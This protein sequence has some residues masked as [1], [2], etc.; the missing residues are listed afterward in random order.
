MAISADVS[1]QGRSR[2]GATVAWTLFWGIPGLITQGVNPYME[3]GT[4]VA[5]TVTAEA[6]IDPAK[7]LAAEA[8][9]GPA[10]LTAT[11]PTIHYGT[12]AKADD[13]K[14]DIERDKDLKNVSFDVKLP[15]GA[16]GIASMNL[17]AVDGVPVPIETKPV[18]VAA[19][20]VVFDGWTLIRYCHDGAT[21]LR[22]RGA[23]VDGRKF[24]ASYQLHVKVVKK[25]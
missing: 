4:A 24:D 13:I 1:K 10:E 8:A 11:I 20:A 12:T 16:Q 6:M 17:V 3:K 15:D 25:G 18:S 2:T 23:L 7:A 19:T 22:F 14:F 21:D 9:T 5:A